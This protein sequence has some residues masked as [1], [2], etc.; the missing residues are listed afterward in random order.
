MNGSLS[1]ITPPAIEPVTPLELREYTHVS[2]DVE[3][4]TFAK[5]I[6]AA[7]I[8]AET[9]QWR[10]YISQV[11]EV[12]YDKWPTLPLDIPRPPLIE[13][14]S[15][16]FIDATNTENTL[17]DSETPVSTNG[18]FVIDAGTIPGRM[19]MISGAT[20]PAV[21]LRS[22]GG[23]RIRFRAGFGSTSETVPEN[24]RFA[25]MLYAAYAS[26]NREGEVP[27]P[28]KEFFNLLEQERMFT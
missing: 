11:W 13:I 12:V 26:G 27:E 15:V 1:L 22:I 24:I 20:W 16:K 9:T 23:V 5:L 25:I 6:K 28:P 3:D 17:Y 10:A 14:L 8:K 21:E 2:H 4:A 19:A 7:R 18:N